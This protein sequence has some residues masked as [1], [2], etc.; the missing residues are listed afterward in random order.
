MID[1]KQKEENAWKP[2][3]A[4]I[5]DKLY[6]IDLVGYVTD[7]FK[8]QGFLESQIHVVPVDTGTG[9]MFFSHYRST[10]FNEPEQRFLCGAGML[11]KES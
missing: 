5:K 1:P 3:V 6:S 9:E 11:K 8:K 7:F 4:H 10:H 2:Y